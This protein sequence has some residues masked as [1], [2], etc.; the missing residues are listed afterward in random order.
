LLGDCCAINSGDSAFDVATWNAI[1]QCQL[2]QVI[3]LD[4][5]KLTLAEKREPNCSDHFVSPVYR[6]EH[7]GVG[8]VIT[9]T[10]QLLVRH[11][12]SQVSALKTKNV[13]AQTIG[14]G[15]Q[16]WALRKAHLDHRL[17]LMLGTRV[18]AHHNQS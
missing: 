2:G 4:P 10:V 11:G 8:T 7:V 15:E 6:H 13:E 12:V 17:P 14:C 9:I 5:N 16:L 1:E 18:S 3:N